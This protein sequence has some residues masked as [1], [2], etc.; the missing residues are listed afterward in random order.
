MAT[1]RFACEERILAL[2]AKEHLNAYIHA[3][4]LPAK[5][6]M[7]DEYMARA[8]FLSDLSLLVN[9]LLHRWDTATLERS[10]DCRTIQRALKDPIPCALFGAAST[11]LI[12]KAW[13]GPCQPNKPRLSDVE[14]SDRPRISC[15]ILIDTFPGIRQSLSIPGNQQSWPE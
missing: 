6:Q 11:Q 8:T 15:K 10:Q 4:I 14:R 12:R 5:R 9:T 2:V 1:Y 3:V 13:I 7:D